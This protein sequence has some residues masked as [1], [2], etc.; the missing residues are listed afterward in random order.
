M[1]AYVPTQGERTI[2]AMVG[3]VFA[4]LSVASLVVLI[5]TTRSVRHL[6]AGSG[7]AIRDDF[8]LRTQLA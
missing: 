7:G 6:R 2:Y 5:G 3:D 8:G 1:V 4:W